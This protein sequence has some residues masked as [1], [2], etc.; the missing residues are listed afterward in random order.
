MK[1][2]FY[3]L[4]LP[5]LLGLFCPATAQPTFYMSNSGYTAQQM[6]TD[7]FDSSY[8]TVSNIVYHGDSNSMAFF[9]ASNTSLGMNAGLFLCTGSYSDWNQPNTNGGTSNTTPTNYSD[10]DLSQIA[11]YQSYDAAVVE[12]DFVCSKDT[13][14]FKYVFGSEE[15]MEFVN[16]AF[17]DVFAFLISGPNPAGG[18]YNN[19]NIATLPNSST[20]VSVDSVNCNYHSQY[21]VCNEVNTG[22]GCNLASCPASTA[23]TVVAFDGYTLPLTCYALVT[24]G[25]T[26]H[27]KFGVSDVTDQILDSGLFLDVQSLGGGF[28]KINPNVTYTTSGNQISFLNSTLYATTHAWDFGDGSTSTDKSPVHTFADLLNES[29]TVSYT[30]TN[31]CGSTTKTFVV[32]N[33]NG[34]YQPLERI[35]KF[36]PN[37]ASQQLTLETSLTKPYELYLNDLQGKTLRH[38]SQQNGTTHIDLSGLSAGMYLL[39]MKYE[40]RMFTSKFWVER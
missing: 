12:F 23:S 25:Q 10:L 19:F 18:T 11:G 31:Y 4:L 7:F 36:Y 28:L 6:V 14:W 24:P 2:Y 8:V 29:Y 37:P 30:G 5:A 15:Y 17:N 35:A 22:A 27:V 13:A 39:G 16:T 38:L 3:A 33:A 32:G 34:I 9:D 1:P 21:Y 26:Y 20:P 40:G